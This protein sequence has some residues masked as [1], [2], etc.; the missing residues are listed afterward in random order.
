[1]GI[2]PREIVRSS[3]EDVQGVLQRTSFP[4]T[5]LF[6]GGA[7]GYVSYD[8][9]RRLE[10]L[11]DKARG[12]PGFP[13]L[14]FGIF[15]SGILFDCRSGRTYFVGD[16]R[17]RLEAL[18][19][20]TSESRAL[21]IKDIR[22]NLSGKGFCRMVEEAKEHI[23]AGDIFQVVLSKRYELHYKGSLLEFYKRLRAINP[24]PYMFY[25]KF[26][27][28]QLIGASPENLVRVEGKKIESFATL[29]GTRQR[30][31]AEA[32]DARL[33]KELLTDEKERAE[34]LMLVDLTRNDVGRVAAPGSVRVPRLMEVHRYSH[35]QHIASKVE[36]KLAGGKTAF[37]AFCSLFPAGTVSGAPK[38]RA[39]EIIE[40]LEPVKRGPYAGAAGYFAPNGCD[41]AIAIRCLFSHGNRAYVQSG[42]GI[43][44]D[45]VPER[46]FTE[47]EN[48]ARALL[49]ALGAKP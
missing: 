32:E 7:I 36:G 40:K 13:D 1:M 6:S 33:R 4:K 43:V 37:D 8:Y 16:D 49:G 42:A 41:F 46:E 15:D 31:A 27:K 47:T 34:H 26:G 21:R 5:G 29:A 22:C 3:L 17:K 20:R 18:L 14:E 11:P 9:V 48:K 30:G 35:V 39:M 23:A 28:R 2:E 25:L 24:S 38:I 12:G 10:E 45:S 44:Y 19:K